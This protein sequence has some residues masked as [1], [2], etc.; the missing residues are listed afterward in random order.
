MS[1]GFIAP[2]AVRC[3]DWWVVSVQPSELGAARGRVR[4]AP[5]AVGCEA[6]VRGLRYGTSSGL[7]REGPGQYTLPGSR[8][9][10]IVCRSRQCTV[11]WPD[12]VPQGAVVRGPRGTLSTR[13]L[14]PRTARGFPRA[15]KA[16]LWGLV[17]PGRAAPVRQGGGA[18]RGASAGAG[19]ARRGEGFPAALTG[20]ARPGY[21][22]PLM[23]TNG[24]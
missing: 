15:I 16:D 18:Y 1:P 17:S 13:A 10:T 22:Q 4:P 19:E 11:R 5:D 9:R 21:T 7:W 3:R 14:A 23:A 8:S 6:S 2:P 24:G 20:A 12:P